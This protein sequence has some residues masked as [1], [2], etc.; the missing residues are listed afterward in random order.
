VELLVSNRTTNEAIERIENERKLVL[1]AMSDH[2]NYYTGPDMIVQ[3]T[4]RAA[5][6]SV[7]LTPDEI[8]GRRCYEIWQ[9]RNEPC[10]ACPVIEA[11]DTEKEVE[12]EMHSP[13]DR[14]WLVKGIPVFEKGKI[15]GV[16]EVT[17]EITEIKQVEAALK[18]SEA[19]Y[20]NLFENSPISLWEEDFSG[21][22]EYLSEIRASGIEDFSLFFSENP[23]KL[24]ECVGRVK[25]LEINTATVELHGASSKEELLGSLG[26]LFTEDAL[27]VFR[28]EMVALAEGATHFESEAKLITLGGE[29]KNIL[30]TLIVPKGYE[31]SLERVIVSMLDLTDRKLA[32][33]ILL[34]Q[35]EEL[36]EFAHAMAHDLRNTIQ[37]ISGYAALLEE[38]HDVSF[39]KQIQLLAQRMNSILQKSVDLADAG[40]LIGELSIVDFNVLIR[41]LAKGI[42]NESIEYKQGELPR[43]VCDREKVIQIIQNI[44][45]N[46]VEHGLPKRIEVISE[47][48]DNDVAIIIKNDG[49]IIPNEHRL[50]LFERGFTTKT[51]S[52]G[53]GLSIV[54]KL[55]EAHGWTI[56]LDN[57]KDTSFRISIPSLHI[58]RNTR[59]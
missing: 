34:N 23:D 57:P 53:L 29:V 17:R 33:E 15:V 14:V 11:Y 26:K 44:L 13:D 8:I 47:Y 37:A 48:S 36:S 49:K 45:L 41:D 21:A 4:N 28:E 3:W 31:E 6:D 27:Y 22:K 2:V 59:S 19:R 20:R 25:I 52:G 55:V 9:M 54:Q 50:K 7:E 46:A 39:A 18:I 40:L 42:I 58:V 5:A 56:Q 10:I 12:R 16:V 38:N 1:D 32:E 24:H 43:I 30:M 35:K 51:A